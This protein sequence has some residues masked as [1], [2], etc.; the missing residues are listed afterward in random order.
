MEKQ[1]EYTRTHNQKATHSK[2][3][4]VVNIEFFNLRNALTLVPLYFSK[5]HECCILTIT[6]HSFPSKNIEYINP[7]L[8][9]IR[10]FYFNRIQF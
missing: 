3:F 9:K 10:L 1:N 8:I 4:R 2:S 5:S 7:H 6:F